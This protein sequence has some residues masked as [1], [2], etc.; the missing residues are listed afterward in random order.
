VDWSHDGQWI[1]Y[2][3]AERDGFSDVYRIH[4]DG[5]GKECLTCNHPQL[6]NKSQGQPEAHPGGRYLVFQAEKAQ[7]GWILGSQATGP[8]GGVYN[9][10]WVM[11]LETRTVYQLTDVDA[12]NLSGS[13]HAHFNHEGTKLL[14]GD[15]E[16]SGGRF[17]DWR[18]A[19]ADFVTVPR[20]HLENVRY[21][22]PGPQ[23]MWLESHGWGPD[24]SWIYFTCTPVAG[25]DDN[26]MDICRM[27]LSNPTRV[28]R[29]TFTSGMSGEP[30]EWDEH[31]HLSPLGDV[32]SWIS[33]TPFGTVANP[34]YGLWLRTDL[35]L[36]NVD[37]SHK[38]RITLFNP[39]ERAI[40]ADNDWN[41]VAT[42]NP[43]LAVTVQ[44]RDRNEVHIK[45]IEFRI[46]R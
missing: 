24:G 23:P 19:V 36:M 8:G 3:H 31:A 26:N 38:Q 7:H 17:G 1:Y 39:S 27:D 4:P 5:T 21:Y 6:P 11:D 15:L 41:P 40:A 35:W 2:D 42:V 13:L 20:P 16:R 10:L 32:F 37:G 25:M 14:W 9:D 33:S 34:F 18:L 46:R 12:N 45:I 30:G 43:Q 28:M 29:L 44:M 22:N